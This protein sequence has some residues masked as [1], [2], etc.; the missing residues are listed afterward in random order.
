MAKV[1]KTAKLTILL[2]H[3]EGDAETVGQAMGQA[4]ILIS[5]LFGGDA[6]EPAGT[7][8]TTK[9]TKDTTVGGDDVHG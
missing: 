5:Q 6:R 9:G 7:E 2:I 3:C 1:K 4:G 8:L